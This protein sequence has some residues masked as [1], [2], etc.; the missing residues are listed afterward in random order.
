VNQ[1]KWIHNAHQIRR[2]IDNGIEKY[3]GV[4]EEDDYNCFIDGMNQ[5]KGGAWHLKQILLDTIAYLMVG[6]DI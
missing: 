2:I 1:D 6:N 5:T 4:M 3:G